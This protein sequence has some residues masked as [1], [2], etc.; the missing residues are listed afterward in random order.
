M[1]D[2][3]I[4]HGHSYFYAHKKVR[5]AWIARFGPL[6]SSDYLCHLCPNG[7]CLN[8]QHVYPG[9]AATNIRDTLTMGTHA[10]V[11]QTHCQNGHEYTPENTY[12]FDGDGG[13]RRCRKCK[14]EGRMR[15]YYEAKVRR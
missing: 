9:D 8:L 14:N 11:R 2:C 6:D 10:S 15:R 3:V 13:A 4:D 1:S 7:T 12:R 5:K